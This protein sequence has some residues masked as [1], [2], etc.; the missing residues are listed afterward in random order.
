MLSPIRK[1]RENMEPQQSVFI[2]SGRI[3]DR[4]SEMLG[5]DGSSDGAAATS[6]LRVLFVTEDDPLYV[7]R[8]FEVFF[9]EY[10]R[11][12][13]EVCGITIDRAFHEP[14]W[15]TLRRMLLFYGYW[16]V[17]RQGLRFLMARLRGR[18]IGALALSAGTPMVVAQSVNH[19]DYI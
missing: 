9:T 8:F 18:S 5:M 7:I 10:P 12:E 14:I 11:E 3:A 4:S 2:S 19:P 13:I 15:K 17:F 6:K 1:E 16:G